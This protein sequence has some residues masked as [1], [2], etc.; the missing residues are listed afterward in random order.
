[1][2]RTITGMLAALLISSAAEAASLTVQVE[3]ASPGQGA[4]MVGI[5][6]GSLDFGSCRYSQTVQLSGGGVPGRVS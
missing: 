4:V 5:C 2:L 6:S 3:G 1:M